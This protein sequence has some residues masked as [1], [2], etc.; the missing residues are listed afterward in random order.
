M[1]V[2]CREL[3]RVLLRV[4]AIPVLDFMRAFNTTGPFVRMIAVIAEDLVWFGA[5]ALVL[6]LASS[7]FFVINDGS[8]EEFALD[9]SQI[10]P[11]WRECECTRHTTHC[12]VWTPPFDNFV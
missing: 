7:C 5:I 2:C 10:G 4:V 11:L 8:Q 3:T 9:Q 6:L 1:H 12:I